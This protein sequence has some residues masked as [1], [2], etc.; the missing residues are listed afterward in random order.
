MLCFQQ[1]FSPEIPS[2]YQP[3][4]TPVLL[5]VVLPIAA[6][7]LGP[8][9]GIDVPFSAKVGLVFVFSHPWFSRV[10]G[11]NCAT[12]N[13]PGVGSYARDCD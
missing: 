7:F 5:A 12:L 8:G 11:R 6:L 1:R 2:C 3:V 9:V 13:T 10:L 4:A